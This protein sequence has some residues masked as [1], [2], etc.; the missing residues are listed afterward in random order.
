MVVL[1]LLEVVGVDVGVEVEDYIVFVVVG[2]VGMFD[3]GIVID[4]VEV[5]EGKGR[6][7]LFCVWDKEVNSSKMSDNILVM[8][9]GFVEWGDDSKD[10]RDSGSG[11]W[12]GSIRK[13]W[14]RKIDKFLCGLRCLYWVC[15]FWLIC[16]L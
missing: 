10:E 5:G 11:L 16:Y 4:V 7:V 13:N 3:Y 15:N 2:G 6:G 8:V 1:L 12:I 9:V 14:K